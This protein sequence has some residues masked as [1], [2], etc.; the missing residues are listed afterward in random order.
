MVAGESF[1][2]AFLSVVLLVVALFE[3]E[4]EEAIQV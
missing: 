3:K 2:D 4:E 1:S